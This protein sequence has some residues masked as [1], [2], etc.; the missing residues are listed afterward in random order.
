MGLTCADPAA[1]HLWT[2]A[3]IILQFIP[4]PGLYRRTRLF[5]AGRPLP[6]MSLRSRPWR[7]GSSRRRELSSGE[8]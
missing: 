8:L 1:R 7:P 6:A 3:K 2:A 5:R 4:G